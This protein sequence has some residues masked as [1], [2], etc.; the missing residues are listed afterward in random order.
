M[1]AVA[2]TT[3]AGPW[4]GGPPWAAERLAMPHISAKRDQSGIFGITNITLQKAMGRNLFP[5]GPDRPT[6]R[7][8]S[9]LGTL[10]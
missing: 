5:G 8:L 4:L 1:W 9:R 6:C 3:F 10:A 2:E 7:P